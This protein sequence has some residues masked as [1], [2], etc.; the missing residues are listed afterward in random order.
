MLPWAAAAPCAPHCCISAGT[1]AGVLGLRPLQGFKAVCLLYSSTHL[2]VCKAVWK[3]TTEVAVQ[4]IQL[5]TEK[6][7]E[8]LLRDVDLL[9]RSGREVQ[10]VLMQ[11]LM[12]S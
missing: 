11:R 3:K 10:W 5:H 12:C 8:S 2:Q 4:C 9:F 1:L 6:A 7:K